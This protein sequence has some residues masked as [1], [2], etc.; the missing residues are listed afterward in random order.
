MP[1]SDIIRIKHMVDS[2][3]EAIFFTNEKNKYEKSFGSCI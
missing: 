1:K 2:V 3:K